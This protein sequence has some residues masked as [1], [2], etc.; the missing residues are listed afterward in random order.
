M[1]CHI[2]T[3]WIYSPVAVAKLASLFPTHV[4]LVTSN[5]L[6]CTARFRSVFYIHLIKMILVQYEKGKA[7]MI[8][9]LPKEN[10]FIMFL[11]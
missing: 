1:C 6:H 4:L 10:E 11:G 2:K 9:Q 3:K 5:Q 7:K 8:L